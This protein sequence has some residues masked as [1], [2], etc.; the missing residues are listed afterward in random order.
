M[1]PHRRRLLLLPMF[2]VLAASACAQ[3]V[4]TLPEVTVIQQ[5]PLPGFGIPRALYPGNAQQADEAARRE[6]GASNLAEFMNRRLQGV[7]ASDVQGSPFQVDITY[8]GQR[9]SPL[10]GTPQGLSL[11]LDGV[12]MNQPFGDIVS[13][14][15]LPEAAIAD[16]VLVPGS[17]PLYGLNTLAGALVLTTRS[18]LT[19]PGGEA[20]ISFGSGQRKRL[21]FAQGRRN[22]DGSHLF[23]AATLFDEQGWRDRSSGKLA[24]VFLKGGRK[25]A[26]TDWSVSLLVAGS[27]LAGNGLL[28]ESLAAADWR[29]VYT[30]PDRTRSQDTLLTFQGSHT[31]DADTTLALQSW[32]RSSSRDGSTG[33]IAQVDAGTSV[34]PPPATFNRSRSRQDEAGL[35]L[36]WTRARGSHELTLGGEVATN[37]LRHDQFTQDAVFD[38]DRNAVPVAGTE[39]QHEVALR[40]RTQ[41]LALF[42]A[43]IVTLSPRTLL[44]PSLRWNLVRV[45]NALGHPDAA[46]DESFRYSKLNPALGASYVVRDGLVLFGNAAQ[47]NRVPTALELGCADPAQPCVLPTGLQADP[48]LR[49]VVSRTFEAGVRGTV[50]Q[51]VQWSAAVFRTDNRD[52][53]VFVRSGVSQAGFF[54]NIDRT[55]RQGL[56]LAVQ[57]RQRT[58]DWSASYNHVD[59][60]YQSSGVLPGPLSTD[61]T[62]NTF[63]PGT[64]LA[65]IPKQ[66]LKLSLGWRALPQVRL[67]VDLLAASGQVVS[68]NESGNVPQLGR[69]AGYGVLNARASWLFARGWEAWLRVNNVT[70]KRFATTAVG[71]FDF[72]PGG[73]TLAPGE[74]PQPARFIGPAAPR[75]AFVGV[76]Y[77]WD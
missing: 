76:R 68:G 37:R 67:G 27:N 39:E 54:T 31:L 12:R 40:G 53:I 70:D 69:V 50:S 35:A 59:A 57:G 2:P 33:D 34:S 22:E 56:E 51:G 10:L 64:R 43:D 25:Q 41:R 13:W 30:A 20:E 46:L 65:G 15:L 45:E 66:V 9:L 21:D 48:F 75:T 42:A 71:N 5:A 6:S 8:R 58:W 77:V 3:E 17:N 38:A 47:G 4:P 61:T 49:Q 36:Q 52:D 62:P 7:I 32:L 63:Q 55:R 19:H 28:N 44:T 24:N 14:D 11:Y 16:L 60:T 26:D 74:D 29:A 73:R 1:T 23:V 18:G 72:F